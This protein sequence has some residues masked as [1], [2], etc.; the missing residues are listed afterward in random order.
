MLFT[1]GHF[2][3]EERWGSEPQAI[4]KFFSTFGELLAF[5]SLENVD[6]RTSFPRI[7]GAQLIGQGVAP[8]TMSHNKSFILPW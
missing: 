8:G 3:I 6:F 2:A 5:E 7:S 1:K 4:V